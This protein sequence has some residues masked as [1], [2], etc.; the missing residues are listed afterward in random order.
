MP[1]RWLCI[2]V[3]TVLAAAAAGAADARA[4]GITAEGCQWSEFTRLPGLST[5]PDT[6]TQV[7]QCVYSAGSAHHTVIRGRPPAAR[8]WSFALID[9]ARREIDNISD[10]QVQLGPDGSYEIAVRV[11]CAGAANCLE[12][13]RSPAPLA[14]E[15]IY[16]RIYVPDGDEFGGVPLP[17]VRYVAEGP[18]DAP[19]GGSLPSPFPDDTLA[20]LESE[21]TQ[22]LLP[23]GE[24]YEALAAASGLEPS[25]APGSTGEDPQP[26]RFRGTGSAQ[27]DTLEAAGVPAPVI[28]LAR[29]AQGQGGF[30][31]TKDNAYA[32]MGF[33]VR[34]GNVELAALAPTYRSQ[35]DIA[36]NGLG[37]DDGSEQVRYWSLCTTQATRPVDC[38]RDE[39]VVL[40]EGGFFRAVISPTC[41]VEGYANCLRSG[42]LGA[43]GG[44]AVGTLIYR[45]T[46]AADSF[47]NDDGPRT[48]PSPDTMFCGDYALSARYV[49][50]P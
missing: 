4:A 9:Q 10:D 43:T 34:S 33:N 29:A 25:V 39:N 50:R 44:A 24:G 18:L 2:L 5:F 7:Y 12:T 45:N 8:F 19:L 37:V 48:C 13:K 38:L 46:A 20:Q 16:H 14:P 21:L 47:Y 3:G 32:T 23:G 1:A 17:S 41:P 26:Q 30:G 15:R 22:P 35:H 40:D 36:A 49:P 6:N 42:A 11:D 27:I 31:A 28:E